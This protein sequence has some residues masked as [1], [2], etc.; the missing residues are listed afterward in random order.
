MAAIKKNEFRRLTE[1]Q[2]KEKMNELKK[3]LMRLNT[4]KSSGGSLEN[5]GKIKS[6]KKTIARIIT[7]LSEK[8]RGIKQNKPIK[9]EMRKI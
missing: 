4:Q 5:P 8:Q 7:M 2:L 9:E 6:V 3:E 1:A